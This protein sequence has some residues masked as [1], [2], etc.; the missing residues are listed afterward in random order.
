MGLD[1]IDVYAPLAYDLSVSSQDVQPIL[2]KGNSYTFAGTIFNYGYDTIVSMN[3][4]YSVN[5]GAPVTCTIAGITGFNELTSYNWTHTTPFVPGAPGAYTVKFWA[6]KLNG[7]NVDQNHANDTL[8][9]HF[10]VPDTLQTRAALYEE[11]SGQSCNPCM[12]SAPNVDS[13]YFQNQA[14]SNLLRYQVPIAGPN[15]TAQRDEMYNETSAS[16]N[17]RSAYYNY[18]GVP[19]GQL[20]GNVYQFPG[21]YVNPPYYSSTTVQ[22]DNAIGS[23]FKIDITKAGYD[24]ST[25]TFSVSANITAYAAFPAGLTAQAVL[26]V[27]SLFFFYDLSEEAPRKEFNKPIG[28]YNGNGYDT[29]YYRYVTKFINVV[30]EMLPSP[31]GTSLK[32]F[33]AGSTQTLNLT[34]KKNHP[35]SA[36]PRGENKALGDSTKYDSSSTAHFVVFV[37]DNSG[38]PAYGVPAQYVYQSASVQIND[39]TGMEEISEGVYFAMYPNPANNYTNLAFKLD[40]EQN[41][42]IEVYNML[43]QNVYSVDKGKMG[44]GEH[45][46]P[47]N[48]TEF[49]SGVY[50]VKFITDNVMTTKKLTIQK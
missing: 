6:D 28:T 41:V 42:S 19:D 36:Y 15:N 22:A 26:A 1:N 32:A 31:S 13:V 35:W 7:T 20:D 24:K 34:W 23:P 40:K 38:T 2:Q 47:V 8:V 18:N 3:M 44:A 39:V 16:S 5:G 37:Q 33:T 48:S 29:S 50:I 10:L 21:A 43:G 9:A 11:I 30:E 27:D 12:A 4:N 45:I 46:I 49:E 25:N 14:T 17:A